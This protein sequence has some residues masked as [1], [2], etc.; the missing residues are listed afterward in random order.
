MIILYSVDGAIMGILVLLTVTF[1]LLA[2]RK[3]NKALKE[4]NVDA[5]FVKKAKKSKESQ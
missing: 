1:V 2:N 5:L 3:Y 4:G